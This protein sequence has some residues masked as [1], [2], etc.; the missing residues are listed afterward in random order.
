[1]DI[2]QSPPPDKITPFPPPNVELHRMKKKKL[3]KL[4]TNCCKKG[5]IDRINVRLN[6]ALNDIAKFYPNYPIQPSDPY[7]RG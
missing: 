5:F 3:N 6:G 2:D 1:M 4:E 7:H